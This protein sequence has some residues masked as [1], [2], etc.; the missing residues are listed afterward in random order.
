MLKKTRIAPYTLILPCILLLVSGI[1]VPAFDSILTGFSSLNFMKSNERTW[2]GLSNFARLFSD[3]SFQRSVRFTLSFIGI[4][5]CVELALGMALA[6]LV[7]DLSRVA[8]GILSTVLFIPYMLAPLTTGLMW[9]LLFTYDGLVNEMLGMIG[10][11]PVSWLGDP[12]AAFLATVIAEIWRSYPFGFL[13]FL[14]AIS[15]LPTEPF[16]A[17]RVDGAGAVQ[18]F[19]LITL[20]LLQPTIAIV[21]IY[22]FVLKLRVFDLVYILTGGGPVDFTMPFGF[23]IYRYYFRYYEAGMGSATSIFVLFLS[24]ASI[25]VVIRNIR[26]ENK[27]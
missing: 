14:S 20:P 16:E 15:A 23:I 19:R 24:I 26:V 3:E 7:S 25:A 2:N 5:M 18:R 12:G 8:K 6:V 21:L 4:T 1:L 11:G 22:Q 27:E 13:L 17:A 9:K 10:P